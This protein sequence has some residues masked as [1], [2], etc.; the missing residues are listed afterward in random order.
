MSLDINKPDPREL[1]IARGH[2]KGQPYACIGIIREH[3]GHR[4]FISMFGE[5]LPW[6]TVSKWEYLKD[7]AP[8]YDVWSPDGTLF[9][10]NPNMVGPGRD[11]P[12]EA[13]QA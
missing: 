1:L 6:Y 2:F 12:A 8:L 5:K 7:V 13:Y 3:D 9:Y 11:E 10:M 4:A